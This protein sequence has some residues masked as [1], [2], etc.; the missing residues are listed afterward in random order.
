MALF[1]QSDLSFRTSSSKRPANWEAASESQKF[2]SKPLTS[3]PSPLVLCNAD[4]RVELPGFV[5]TETFRPAGLVLP[6][7]FHEYANIAL[8]VEGS[9]IETVGPTPYEVNPHSVIFR[10][11]GE[12]HS[13]RYGK[14]AAHCLI[15]EVRPQR[16]SELR[17]VTQILD[18]ASYVEGGMIPS[19]ALR[20]LREFRTLDAVGPLSIEALTLE[21]LVQATRLD[22]M[23]DRNPPRWLQ[24]AREVIHEQFLESVSLSSVA[25]LVGVH[26]A[27][28]ARMFRRHY[29]CTLGDYVRRVRLDYAAQ[30]LARP[31]ETLSAIAVAAGFYDQ[32][33]FAHLFK[34]RFGVTPGVFRTGL[35]T[36]RTPIPVKCKDLPSD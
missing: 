22:V 28:L 23:R 16:L 32:S 35:R 1:Q 5:L 17:E 27:H 19:L 6:P 9:F 15:I 12:K 31:E 3:R 14:T 18:R 2:C 13:N 7:H 8:D 34:L 10:P 11:A 29:G 21:M 26:A 30:L 33:H 25:E 20:I 24:Q 36:R 4:R